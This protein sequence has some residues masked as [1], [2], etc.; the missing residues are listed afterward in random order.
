[1]YV[2][3]KTHLELN[4]DVICFAQKLGISIFC[5]SWSITCKWK[6]SKVICHQNHWVWKPSKGMHHVSSGHFGTVPLFWIT[7]KISK[8]KKHPQHV[9]HLKF[10][11]KHPWKVTFQ[12]PFF[13][14]EAVKLRESVVVTQLVTWATL[15]PS[16]RT[17]SISWLVTLRYPPWP[18]VR[19]FMMKTIKVSFNKKGRTS[20]NHPSF[21]KGVTFC[22]GGFR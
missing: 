14:G 2:Y 7:N 4:K 20:L 13:R 9:A 8:T 16:L 22:H 1:M 6:L 18:E 21:S 3:I 19:G 17:E 10:N 5:E 11:S 15:G 12:P